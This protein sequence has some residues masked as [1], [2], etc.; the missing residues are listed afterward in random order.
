MR[1]TVQQIESHGNKHGAHYAGLIGSDERWKTV[2]SVWLYQV[3]FSGYP[4]F[5]FF[6]FGR[7]LSLNRMMYFSETRFKN[8][9]I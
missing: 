8:S 3:K 6:D 9:E 2:Y 5:Q 4:N 1:N 7:L